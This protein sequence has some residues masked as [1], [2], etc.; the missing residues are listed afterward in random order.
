MARIKAAGVLRHF[1]SYS[2]CSM[3]KSLTVGFW[4]GDVLY[5][6]KILVMKWCLRVHLEKFGSA[7]KVVLT[8]MQT[9]LDYSVKIKA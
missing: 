5:L 8:Q 7:V 1:T 4:I 3:A 6:E 2:I 9:R